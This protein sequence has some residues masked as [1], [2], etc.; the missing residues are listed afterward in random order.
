MTLTKHAR[1]QRQILKGEIQ[2]STTSLQIRNRKKFQFSHYN[3]YGA[4]F[5]LCA[6]DDKILNH[7]HVCISTKQKL[8]VK[9]RKISKK[10]IAVTIVPKY[11]K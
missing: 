4:N 10:K 7:L 3:R 9:I 8:K 11:F 2:N 1:R 5:G 6:N